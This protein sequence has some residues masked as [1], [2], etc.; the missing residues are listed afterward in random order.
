MSDLGDGKLDADRAD[1]ALPAGAAGA[2]APPGP[3]VM[4]FPP[5]LAAPGTAG[6]AYEPVA[7]VAEVPP[8]QMLRVTRGDLDIL[9]AHTSSGLVAT[10]DRCPHMSAPLSVGRL[11]GCVV[12]CPLHS[13]RFDLA[14]GDVVQFP[15]TG[16]L[17]AD[18]EYHPTWTPA[19]SPPKPEP[20]GLKQLARART[21]VRRLRYFPVRVVADTIELALPD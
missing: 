1:A 5:H 17:D 3:A 2:D 18:G 12:D 19:G 21:R 20:P 16:G 4:P 6:A 14:T 13:G 7:S 15:T 9:L 11:E 8:G 10:E